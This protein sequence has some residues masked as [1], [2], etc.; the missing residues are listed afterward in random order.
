MRMKGITCIIYAVCFLFSASGCAPLFKGSTETVSFDSELKG[1]KVYIN[2][3]NP[4]RTPF[5]TEL[6]SDKEH[7]CE[8]DKEG[9]EKRTIVINN[10]TSGVFLLCL[11]VLIYSV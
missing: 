2:G 6:M 7:V 5:E 4:G 8:F 1:A 10:S 3:N 9:F 11:N